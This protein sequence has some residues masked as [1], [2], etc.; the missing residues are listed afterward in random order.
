MQLSETFSRGLTEASV[1]CGGGWVVGGGVASNCFNRNTLT[2]AHINYLM[3]RLRKLHIIASAIS[4]VI[5]ILE[6]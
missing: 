1:L 4:G 3:G 5:S 6:Q 2:S